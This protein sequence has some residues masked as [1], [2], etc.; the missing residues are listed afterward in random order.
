MRYKRSELP[1]HTILFAM[2]DAAG[3]FLAEYRSRQ[4]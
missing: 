3:E 4:S 2:F 1:P